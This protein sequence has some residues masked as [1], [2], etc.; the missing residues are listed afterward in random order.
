MRATWAVIQVASF[1]STESSGA[2]AGP[3][4][5]L[6]PPPCRCLHHDAPPPYTSF[7]RATYWL[8]GTTAPCPSVLWLHNVTHHVGTWTDW[9]ALRDGVSV[10][11]LIPATTSVGRSLLEMRPWSMS[12]NACLQGAAHSPM[13]T[14][15]NTV[16]GVLFEPMLSCQISGAR[17]I[18]QWTTSSLFSR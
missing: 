10:S 6:P 17:Q 5:S 1:F 15:D 3:R 11:R 8:S 2:M 9:Q 13:T 18:G 12:R 4:C 14:H 7:P 16:R